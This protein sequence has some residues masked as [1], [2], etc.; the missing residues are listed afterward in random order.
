VRRRRERNFRWIRCNVCETELPIIEWEEDSSG[1]GR[2]AALQMDGTANNH[3][4]Q[5]IATNMIRAKMLASDFDVFLAHNSRDKK[6]VQVLAD[7]LREKGLNP[8]LDTEQVPPGRWFQDVIQSAIGRVRSV[9]IIVGPLGMG[10]WELVELRAFLSACVDNGI[11]LIPVLLPG[12]SA[13][14]EDLP[15][16]R[17]LNYVRFENALEDA[18]A[19]ARLEWGIRADRDAIARL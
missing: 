6:A 2:A 4:D 11:P 8:W 17:E 1:A 10:K 14:P 3:R 13:V 19:I 12:V 7:K 18:K 16:L 9:A 15:F 5:E